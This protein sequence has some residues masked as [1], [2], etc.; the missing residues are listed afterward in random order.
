MDHA[1]EQRRELEAGNSPG[2]E[3]GRRTFEE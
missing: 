3:R 2:E 1:R